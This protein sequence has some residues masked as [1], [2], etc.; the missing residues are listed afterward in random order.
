[1]DAN[2]IQQVRHFN[3]MVTQRVGA[4]EDSYLRRGRPLGEARLIFETGIHG[5]DVRTLRNRLGL[6]SGYLSR[7]LRS[8]EAQGLIGVRRHAGDARLR[9][10]SLTPKGHAEFATYEDLSD[11]LAKSILTPL[12]PTQRERLVAA[13]NEVER[14]IRA[15]SIDVRVEAPSSVDARWC[16]DEYFRE[17][18]ERFDTGFDPTKSNPARDEDVTPPAGYFVVARLDGSPVGCGALRRTKKTIGEIKRMWTAPSARG[19][20]IARRVLQTLEA[21][22][23]KTGLKTLRLETNRTLTEAQTL[24]RQEGYQEVAPFNDEPYAHH[25][26]EKRL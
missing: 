26:F 5:A 21:I 9:R 20:G 4:L 10:V 24:Y 11:D 8:L 22:A 25:W 12:G 19:Q 3:R 1:M 18:A 14:L 2:Q 16:L 6:D 13:M 17:L 7:L 23:R 15:A